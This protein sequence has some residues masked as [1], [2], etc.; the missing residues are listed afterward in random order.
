MPRRKRLDQEIE[1]IPQEILQIP[2]GQAM[3]DNYLDIS[4]Y[5]ANHRALPSLYDGCIS[6]T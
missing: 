1:Q 6:S 5:V 3:Q 4:S 2:M